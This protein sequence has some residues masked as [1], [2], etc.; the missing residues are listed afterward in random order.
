MRILEFFGSK[1]R[2]DDGFSAHFHEKLAVIKTKGSRAPD[3]FHKKCI[4]AQYMTRVF[5]VMSF[6]EGL[7]KGAV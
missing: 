3:V 6:S 1:C 2:C 5:K 4:N 7:E